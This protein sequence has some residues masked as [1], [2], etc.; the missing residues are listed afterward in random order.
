MGSPQP[1][2]QRKYEN[3]AQQKP[4]LPITQRWSIAPQLNEADE[5]ANQQY[6]PNGD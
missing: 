5:A 4:S 2:N 3:Q 1:R 6:E